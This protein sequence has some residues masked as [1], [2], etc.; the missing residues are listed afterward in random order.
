MRKATVERKTKETAIRRASISTGRAPIDIATGIGFLDH[1][2]EQ[3]ARHSPDRPHA[4]GQ[5]RPAHRLPPHH[6][7]RRHRPRP[8][9]G[10]GAR[11]QAG[12]RPLRL[13]AHLPMDE[14]LTRVAVD[15]SGRPL[16]GLE[17]RVPDAEDRRHRHRAVPRVVPGVRPERRH[18]AARREPLRREQPPHRR[19][20][21]Q[22][23]WR[24]RCA[25]PSPSI[26]ARPAACP[27]PRAARADDGMRLYGPCRH[28][29]VRT[30]T[31]C[32]T[33]STP[34]RF[35]RGSARRVLLAP[36]G[37]PSSGGARWLG[38]S[39]RPRLAL[40]AHAGSSSA[41]WLLA[42][43]LAVRSRRI[44]AAGV[45]LARHRA[46]RL[47]G[48]R[49]RAGALAHA[50]LSLGEIVAGDEPAR[51]PSSASSRPRR[52][53][54]ARRCGPV[55]GAKPTRWARRRPSRFSALPEPARGP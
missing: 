16:S 30:Q 21:L 1:M 33:P 32:A 51:R 17:G 53:D 39:S 37:S 13:G 27:R 3:L 9:G 23:R 29:S 6:R 46:A 11:R 2:L 55:R 8:G 40:S 12:H 7:G 28:A 41:R 22:G 36:R 31:G 50:R 42:G 38:C 19:D 44:G 48:Q 26:R 14:T 34:C 4:Q 49:S 35:T 24:A 18:H 25:R 5:G 47:G 20:L 45:S 52:G 43:C 10:Q 15:V 54:P